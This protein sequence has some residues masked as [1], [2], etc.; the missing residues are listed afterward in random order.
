MRLP[1]RPQG[2]GPDARWCQAIHDAVEILIKSVRSPGVLT[3]FTTRGIKRKPIKTDT[4]LMWR[5]ASVCEDG[6]TYYVRVL[7]TRRYTK[8]NGVP[9][10]P[11]TNQPMVGLPPVSENLAGE[12]V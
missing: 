2:N 12:A 3:S 4:G 9:T 11:D 6:E 7:S 10:D 5:E 1:P 8:V